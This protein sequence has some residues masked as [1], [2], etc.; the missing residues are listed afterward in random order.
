[1]K[2][3]A[4]DRRVRKTQKAIKEGFAS[5]MLEKSIQE[6]SVRELTELVDINRSTFYLHYQDIYDL[7]LHIEDETI[8]EV[9]AMLDENLPVKTG[10]RPYLLFVG[11]LHYV[12]ENEEQCKMLLS[13]NNSGTFLAKLSQVLSEKCFHN[14]LNNLQVTNE[15]HEL[16]YF[17]EFLISGYIAI[18]RSWLNSGKKATPEELAQMMESMALY[19]IGFLD[20]KTNKM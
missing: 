10:D 6:I 7:L 18:I 16:E 13:Y 9:S 5:L 17:N 4:K 2:E 8:E 14:W 3:K 19:G 20:R 1:M 11:V 15:P 12:S